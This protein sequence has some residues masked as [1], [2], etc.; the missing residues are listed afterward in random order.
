MKLCFND[1]EFFK[2]PKAYLSNLAL[3]ICVKPRLLF[4]QPKLVKEL[5]STSWIALSLVYVIIRTS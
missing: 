2:A 3:N 4:L 5:F 1:P